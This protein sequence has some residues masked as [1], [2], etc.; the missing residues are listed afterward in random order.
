[1]RRLANNRLFLWMAFLLTMGVNASSAASVTNQLLT[2]SSP[3]RYTTNTLDG[4]SWTAPAYDDSAWFGPSSGL[5]YIETAALPAAK[6]TPLPAG[7]SGYP[8]PCY[9]FRTHFEATNVAEIAAL[10][11]QHLVD[12]GAVFYLNGTE[13]QR[14][15]MATGEVYNAT[16]AY[17][18]PP[19]GDAT[20]VESFT[21][22]SGLRDSLVEGTNCLA[23]R[24]HQNSATSSDVVFGVQLSVVWDPAPVATL[25]RGPYLMV[26]TPSS[27]VVRWRTDYEEDSLVRYGTSLSSM[28]DGVSDDRPVTEHKLTITNLAADTVYYYSVG[29]AARPLAGGDSTCFFKTAPLPG[30]RLPLRIWA[31]GDPGTA[32][33]NEKA[34]VNAF[35][36]ANNGRPV[37]A[38][39][40]LG[41][42]AYDYGTDAQYQAAIFDLCA[43]R[44]RQTPVWPC[45]SNHDTYSIDWNGVF[46]YFNIYDMPT[47]GEAGGVPSGSRFYYSFDIGMV[48]LISLDG[49]LSSRASSGAMATWLRSDLAATTSQWVIAF[50]HQ[51]PYTKGSHDSD[52]EIEPIEMRQ[53]I[54]P[55]IEAGGVDLVLSGHSHSYERSYLLN[56]HYGLSTTLTGAMLLDGTTGSATNGA[57][58]YAKPETAIGT[59]VPNRGTVYVVAGSSGKTSGGT[60]NHPAM[61]V[62][63]NRL[64]SLVLDITTNRLSAVFLRETGETNDWFAI[65]K[66]N[67]APVASS[68]AL[69]VAANSST[70]V[71]VRADDPNRNPVSY[72]V[73]R[74][75]TNGLVSAFDPSTGSFLYT[76][77]RGFTGTDNLLFTASDGSL[78]SATASV[79]IGVA[80]PLDTNAN[81]LPDEW[82]ARYGLS[83]PGADPDQDGA[84]NLQEYIAGT[85]PKD[86]H[87]WLRM[88]EAGPSS[89]AYRIVWSS[90]GGVRY[91]ILF[92]DGD[93]QGGFNGVFTPLIRTV[94]EEMDPR[95]LGTEGTLSFTDDF[96]LTGRPPNNCRFYRIAV[97]H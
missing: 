26:S 3:W 95:P 75:P 90:V 76:P 63:Y 50:W 10:K 70:N 79:T 58:G 92:C 61:A 57:G 5:F 78:T 80:P 60:L 54:A 65:T 41:D 86:G 62:S 4:V 87:S 77:A 11:F 42:N 85:N 55:I 91:R 28:T 1:M 64:G 17:T 71:S 6:V 9:Y 20:S 23:V 40:H 34:V 29:S 88:T 32:N 56:G 66:A 7:T 97:I 24:V 47:R 68:A 83:D 53:N 72:A 33:A 46:P 39:L 35:E 74:P 48:H 36:T 89:S 52:T 27:I 37:N 73:L 31:T 12:D 30:A 49:T 84:T 51:P 22:V 13:I 21:V 2:F 45:L 8:R 69:T 44:L 14:I 43:L 67:F 25:T 38:W 16:L 94:A 82:E 18:S 96:S 93:A 81:G 19:G 59:P 15:R